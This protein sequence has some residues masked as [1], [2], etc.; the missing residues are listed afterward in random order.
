MMKKITFTII[1]SLLMMNIH[2]QLRDDFTTKKSTF[3]I[4]FYKHASFR[5]DK[6]GFNIYVDPVSGFA[7]YA[8]EPKADLIFITHEHSDHF[9]PVAVA[10][11]LKST[12]II[13]CN[14][15]VA[16]MLK[17]T[18][19]DGV[20]IIEMKN[21]DEQTIANIPIQALPAYNTTHTQFHP[22]G[23]DNGYLFALDDL[24]IYVAGDCEN[25]PEM[26][27]LQGKVDI[28][29]LPVN[30]PYTMT[31]EQ[32]AL[33]VKAIQPKIFYPYHYGQVDHPTDLQKLQTLLAGLSVEMRIRG[34]E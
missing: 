31:E 16:G 13:V 12:T 17:Q 20:K 24:R 2:A 10:I 6:E 19:K 1:L 32:A 8:K 21:G 29:F 27:Q 26:N 18:Y 15:S 3:A 30:Q 22:Q 34:M 4:S 28:A 9:D 25:M 23:R 5:I 11:L 14:P 7:D 33:A